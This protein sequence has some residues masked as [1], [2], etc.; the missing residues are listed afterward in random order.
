ML[1][2]SSCGSITKQMAS[3]ATFIDVQDLDTYA[4]PPGPI[5]GP[6]YFR[7]VREL[8]EKVSVTNTQLINPENAK[9]IVADLWGQNNIY[10]LL[11]NNCN[12]F[13]TKL[14]GKL[15]LTLPESYT[16][17]FQE[18]VEFYRSIGY[19]SNFKNVP[20][21]WRTGRHH[22]AP[23]EEFDV[24][25][26]YDVSDP[27][28]PKLLRAAGFQSPVNDVDFLAESKETVTF[29]GIKSGMKDFFKSATSC[30][31]SPP[32]VLPV[33][34]PFAN[35]P[36]YSDSSSTSSAIH[37]D[38]NSEILGSCERGGVRARSDGLDRRAACTSD[39]EK[40]QQLK[41][42]GSKELVTTRTTGKFS[43]VAIF[44]NPAVRAAGVVGMVAAVAFIII[45]FIAG[46][47]KAVAWGLASLAVGVVTSLLIAGPVGIVI[48]AL[49]GALFAILPGLFDAKAD[50][51]SN[52]PAQIIQYASFGDKDHTGNEKCNENRKAAGLEPN[53]PSYMAQIYDA[54]AF[55]I[56]YNQGHS[57]SILDMA[58]AFHVIDHAISNDGNNV[59]ATIDC[60]TQ[61]P[62][63][64]QTNRFGGGNPLSP[65]AGYSCHSPK[66]ALKRN[67]ITLPTLG[68]TADKIY[69]RIIPEP[70]RDCK[71]LSDP[72]EG[73]FLSV[74]NLT[75]YGRPVAI[76]CGLNSSTLLNG[77]VPNGIISGTNTTSTGGGQNLTPNS[78]YIYPNISTT[79]SSPF[80]AYEPAPALIP[81][82][83]LTSDNATCLS[84][85][86]GTLCLP[87]GNQYSIQTGLFNFSTTSLTTVTF[88]ATGG[89]LTFRSIS[90][91]SQAAANK[92]GIRGG[93][94]NPRVETAYYSRSGSTGGN[95]TLNSRFSSALCVCVYS[96]T[97]FKGDVRC[98]GPGGGELEGSL[99]AKA[100]SVSLHANVTAWIYADKY[101]DRGGA[102]L[103]TDVADLGELT[104]GNSETGGQKGWQ[105]RVVAL[106]IKKA[107]PAIERRV[108]RGKR[109]KRL[110]SG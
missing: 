36:Q 76:A 35:G 97:Q 30:F 15:G 96:D 85:T 11:D 66:F 105:M 21:A 91:D 69:K 27:S 40:Y 41:Q 42:A 81:F 33:E 57:M 88:P 65:A 77:T 78:T 83:P 100:K 3:L 14:C 50:P 8:P 95:D 109:R 49:L 51:P 9:G 72:S 86:S 101:D 107:T 103:T 23:D 52:N 82:V 26:H 56:N 60:G 34:N 61:L 32:E 84:S 28:N 67:L 31:R 4:K 104:Y 5:Y 16:Q 10:H 7:E 13:V 18:Q 24:N 55:L 44:D 102:Y 20:L 74:V 1:S 17:S 63:I 45:D 62:G 64:S 75:I 2:E 43:A 71:I 106:W 22:F 80:R 99:R 90:A 59:T 47:Y 39:Q 38:A 58:N 70:N 25:N 12:D 108:W 53:V 73:F 54:V 89:T 94:S 46:D 48:G 92:P 6:N 68:D 19:G 87:S 110:H 93:A 98:F 29:R 79:G 37:D